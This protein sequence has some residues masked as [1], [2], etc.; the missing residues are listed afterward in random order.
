MKRILFVILAG[1]FLVGAL[2]P[3]ALAQEQPTFVIGVLDDADGSIGLGAQLGADRFNRFGGVR[4]ADGTL[5]QLELIIEPFDTSRLDETVT[6]FSENNVIA[7]IGPQSGEAL[8]ENLPI[9]QTLQVPIFTPATIDQLLEQDT[10]GLIYRSQASRL[11]Q[12]RALAAF[13]V[14]ELQLLN[15]ITVKVDIEDQTQVDSLAFNNLLGGAPL[16]DMQIQ[17]V[18]EIEQVAQDISGLATDVVVAFGNP[19]QAAALY[20]ALR[21]SGFAGFFA[22]QQADDAFFRQSVPVQQLQGVIS[23]AS[24]SVANDEPISNAFVLDYVQTFE[25][26]PDVEA[27]ASY[28]AILLI[29][30]AIRQGGV[31]TDTLATLRSLE[32][33]QGILR[34]PELAPRE[35]T[36]H[37]V[38]LT[39]NQFG[40]PEVMAHYAGDVRLPEEVFVTV[41]SLVQNVRTGP[42]TDF[43]I[44]GQIDQG[45]RLP[46]L[47]TNADKTWVVIDYRGQQGWMAAYL[48]DIRGNLDTTPIIEEPTPVVVVVQATATPAP[49]PAAGVEADIVI[50]NAV[51]VPL[52]IVPNQPFQID[53][54]VRNAGS[55]DAGEFGVATTLAPDGLYLSAI[56]PGLPA[57]QSTTTS[58][59]GTLATTGAFVVDIVADLNNQVVENAAGENNNTFAMIYVVNKNVA[60]Q[61]MRQLN[62]GD[63]MDLEGDTVE[64]PNLRMDDLQWD[65]NVLNTI[66]NA[67]VV[68]LVP[69]TD[70]FDWA[71]SGANPANGIHWNLTNPDVVNR[72]HWGLID[73]NVVNQPNIPPDQIVP[74]TVIGVV[75]N[76]GNRGILRV[77]ERLDGNR[78]QVTFLVYDE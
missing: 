29:A 73:P 20:Q 10:T 61:D 76:D 8:I 58:L 60:R 33:V 46:I 52:P 7:I 57:G 40:G 49:Q 66:G 56:V 24:W 30:A 36:N 71:N 55:T 64:D 77:D 43:E 17:E 9:L 78:M 48:L 50:D 53:V 65:G 35:M 74:G 6:R 18:G 15:I 1:I 47:G 37:T 75:T 32:G 5:F 22:F 39:Y 21:T 63:V 28:D 62:P 11:E 69:G 51:I 2:T 14:Q 54:T 38:I 12:S 41:T 31:F 34:A 4:G 45:T 19:A 23:T 67:R 72:I 16:V 13:L 3:L 70:G 42:S 27:V 44:L 59:T 26:V 68:V 25:A